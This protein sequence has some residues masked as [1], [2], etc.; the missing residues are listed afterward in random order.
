MST[1]IDLETA[2]EIILNSPYGEAVEDSEI[3][4]DGYVYTLNDGSTVMV[5]WNGL[6][7]VP[8]PLAA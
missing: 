4:P 2:D 7:I 1:L 3:G 6:V 8:E 5:D